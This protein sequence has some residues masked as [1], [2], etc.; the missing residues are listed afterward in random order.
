[1]AIFV[2]VVL[3]NIGLPVPEET[4]LTIGGYLAWQGQL[5]FSIVVLVGIVSA[6]AGDNLG[7]WLGRRHGQRMLAYLM[8]AAPGRVE[9]MQRFVRN[10]GALSVFLARFVTG[11]RFMAGPL[12]GSTGLAPWRFF[13]AN[14]LGAVIYAP[15]VV[16]VGYAVGLGLGHRIEELRRAAGD[17]ER[18]IWIGLIVAAIGT[19]IVLARRARRRRSA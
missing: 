19:W 18:F 7:Y 14:L 8:A 15:I 11:L 12:A 3:G 2:I 10:H 17:A 16:G 13:I 4:V 5:R 6:I 9:R 1:V